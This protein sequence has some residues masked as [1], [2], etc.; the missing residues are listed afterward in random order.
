MKILIIGHGRHGKD[1]VAEMISVKTGL[2]NKS[3]SRAALDLVVF[4]AI[5]CE[6]KNKDE[7]F[8]DRVHRRTLW[9]DLISNFNK[10]DPT[11]LCRH[12]LETADIY[13]GMR[14]KAELE[15][16]SMLFDLIIWVDASKRLPPEKLDSCSVTAKHAAVIIDNNSGLDS[17][18]KSVHQ[19]CVAIN[20]GKI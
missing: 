17:L 19:L 12:L 18:E 9:F 13:I 16:S 7:C 4:P 3:S 10:N 8:E 15:A 5:G 20:A 11:R 6:Y 1:T 14:S 2:I